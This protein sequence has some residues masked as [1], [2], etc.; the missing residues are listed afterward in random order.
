MQYQRTH[1]VEILKRTPTIL[2]AWLEGLPD[3]WVHAN[4][5]GESWSAFDLVGHFIHGELTDWIPRA[6]I[7]LSDMANKEFTPFDRFAQFENSK[8][9]SLSDLL[10]EFAQLRAANVERLAAMNIGP[11]TLK[12]AGIHPEFGPV[13]LEQLLA[14]WVTHDYAHLGQLARVMAKQYKDAVGPWAN[15]IPLLNK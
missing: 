12:L 15:Y 1:A 9:K 11:A 6:N 10:E 14:T 3:E 8:G 2:K 5:G 7:I 4:E 13:T